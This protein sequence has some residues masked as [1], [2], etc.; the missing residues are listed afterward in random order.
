M[1]SPGPTTGGSSRA[2]TPLLVHLSR[3]AQ[4][5]F[6][7][8]GGGTKK[9]EVTEFPLSASD[10]APPFPACQGHSVSYSFGVC[11]V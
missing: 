1:T 10:L 5:A 9:A 4:L 8:S 11:F 7:K 6:S 3:L 2:D